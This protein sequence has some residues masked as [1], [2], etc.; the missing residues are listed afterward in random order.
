M[1]R[2]YFI[3]GFLDAGKTTFIKELFTQDY[4]KTAGNTLLLICEEGDEEYDK[5]VLLDNNVTIIPIENESDFNGENIASI[6]SKYKPSRVII[7]FNG[8]WNRKEID[9][10]WYW[11]DIVD[12]DIIDATTFEIYSK[13]MKPILSEHVRNSI[14]VVMNRCDNYEK[15]LAKYRRSIKAVKQD[16]N[17][18]FYD[19]NGEMSGRLVDDLPYNIDDDLINIDNKTYATFY[20]DIMENLDRYVGKRVKFT[21]ML[22]KKSED[23]TTTCIL[24]RFAMTCCAEDLSLFGFVCEYGKL[25]ELELDDWAQVEAIIDKDYFE[26]YSLWYPVFYI[27]KLTRCDAPENDVVDIL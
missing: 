5:Q 22:I 10:P 18:V 11:E 26:K 19:K 8:M 25:N 14:M 17:V 20:L 1:A 6:E 27:K 21:G 9:Y 2:V 3:N 7:E 23:K 12:V 4:F 16:I 15:N 24:G 13:N